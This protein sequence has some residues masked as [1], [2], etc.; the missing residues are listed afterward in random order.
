MATSF[1]VISLGISPTEID[2]T[3]SDNISDA[4]AD[5]VGTTYGSSG[6]PLFNDVRT[7]ALVS[8]GAQYDTD[9][10]T[11][12]DQFSVDGTT[13]TIDGAATY[14]ATLT[15]AD[16]TSA[17]LEVTLAQATTGDLFLLPPETGATGQQAI[18]E[19]GPIQSLTLNSLISNTIE[20]ATDRLATDFAEPVDGAATAEQMAPGYTDTDGDRIGDG[21]D[22]IFGNGG[23]DTIFAGAGNDIVDGGADN[24]LIA[25]NIGNDM[26]A[27]GDG[28]DTLYGDNAGPTT[29]AVTN[30]D[31]ANNTTTGWTISGGGATFS[32]DGILAFNA[33]D[34]GF[35]GVA[36][37]TVATQP[38]A[39]FQLS[40]DAAEFGGGAATHTLVVD[41]LDS[42]GQVIA[43]QTVLVD[44]AT[45]Q[46]VTVDF[47]AAT[48]TTTLRFTNPTS[49]GTVTTDLVLDNIAVTTL[50]GD[51]IDGD[52][53]LDGGSGNDALFG[54]GGN[55]S[56]LGGAGN[57]TILGDTGP[58]ADVDVVNGD[59]ASNTTTGW[60][61]SGGGSTFAYD[62]FLGFNA[63]DSGVGGVA[64]QTVTTQPGVDY[65]LSVDAA[66]NGSAVASHTL[67]VD[68]LDASGLVLGTQTVVVANGTS[69]TITIDFT[70][71]GTATTLRFSNPTSTGTVNTDLVID[72]ITVSVLSPP[73]PTG[74]GNDT[75]DGG[76][77]DDQIFAAGGSDRI[78]LSNDF[79]NDVIFGG[80][81]TDGLDVD[82]LD[83]SGITGS[84][85]T[86]TLTGGE[87]G[88][89]TLGANSAA[90]TEIEEIVFTDQGDIFNG[91]FITDDIDI[92]TGDGDDTLT[93]GNGN[94]TL[95]G[96]AGDD[97]FFVGFGDST[98]DGG[99]GTDTLSAASSDDPLN[100]LFTGTGTG[101]YTDLDANPDQGIF[102]SIEA[103]EGSSG[104]DTINASGDLV[105][106]DLWG[107]DGD[108]TITG[109]QGADTI[110]GD[111][112]ND[113]LTGGAG[114]DFFN[115][116]PGDGLD[117]ISDFN[118]GNTG[119][120][121]DGDTTNN[122]FID[123]SGFYD[124]LFELWADQADDGILNQSN[125]T[126]TQGNAVDYS[127]N[128]QFDTDG[129]PGNEGI[130]FTGASPS[131][132]FFN[133]DNTGVI[134]FADGTLIE[135][136]RGLVP[137]EKLAAGDMVRTID[138][139]FRPLIWASHTKM[140]WDASPH[141]DKPIIIK[142]GALGHGLPAT[143]LKV[144]PQHRILLPD[145]DHHCGVFAP[146]IALLGLPGV[147]Q[148]EG[149][150]KVTYHHIM[151]AAHEVIVAN[152]L[153]CESFFPGR[154]AL[155]ALSAE[156]RR[157]LRHCLL[158]ATAGS[159]E[160][161]TLARPILKTRAA[162]KRVH[163][164]QVRWI[165]RTLADAGLKMPALC[166][167]G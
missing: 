3:E 164:E 54:G 31:F 52:D 21:N 77:G 12:N 57:D 22:V 88:T 101:T 39:R 136:P 65:Q 69:Q 74:D 32:Y 10:A 163:R 148:M 24:D 67:V 144:S 75:I 162:R 26:L 137:V 13:F 93:E 152:G 4:A 2:T 115:Y 117:T 143:D 92:D 118:T 105:G 159:L 61:I 37:Q 40:L 89:V 47:T 128:T 87:S 86:V 68:I 153:P 157:S 107:F 119:P 18:L 139:G 94:N 103:I 90:F 82:V 131:P 132:T 140:S 150:R 114:D 147:R 7:L 20:P 126:D 14:L 116:I 134:C 51:E 27:G 145:T 46:T 63:A 133:A 135:T 78:Q 141:S 6:A 110:T 84:G 50:P 17:T 125:T 53:T 35:G 19:A 111:L 100:V 124:H 73:D 34:S 98:I 33:S 95:S 83:A 158:K 80:E 15:Y 165:D 38:G 160:S 104:A 25:G 127:D 49:T 97:L 44:D 96:G 81:D 129:I 59:F 62:G 41:I 70:A 149:C 120:I 91:N 66:E 42:T 154:M 113:L 56:L 142:A 138:H 79:G 76:T 8:G 72:N 156:N 16:G 122:D 58:F 64:Q 28:D 161:F 48:D 99:S 43:T 167:F 151:F 146:A 1:E 106:V 11:A 9:N 155:R 45:T 166:A 121:N 36:Q 109:G 60:T 71:T 30:G 23:A 85:I 108:D 130:V 123:L 55:D 29:V 5:L 112:G 102:S